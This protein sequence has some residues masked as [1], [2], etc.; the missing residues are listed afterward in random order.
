LSCQWLAHQLAKQMKVIAK[1]GFFLH[2]DANLWKAELSTDCLNKKT[3]LLGVWFALILLIRK[4]IKR[5]NT[6]LK[7]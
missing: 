1:A 2:L 7:K 4:R 6:P 5:V 3:S